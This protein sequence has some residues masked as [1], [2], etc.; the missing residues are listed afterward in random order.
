[1]NKIA[2][3]SQ[4]PI[5]PQAK[6]VRNFFYKDDIYFECVFGIPIIVLGRETN[7]VKVRKAIISLEDLIKSSAYPANHILEIKPSMFQILP[8]DVQKAA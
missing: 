6:I 1:M 2:F 7:I 3:A 8:A 4:V 5:G